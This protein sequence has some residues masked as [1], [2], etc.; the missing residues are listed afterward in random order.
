MPIVIQHSASFW[1]RFERIL[2]AKP[3]H[4]TNGCKYTPSKPGPTGSLGIANRTTQWRVQRPQYKTTKYDD[5]KK[6]EPLV[7]K[8]RSVFG[9]TAPVSTQGW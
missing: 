5:T 1:P 7:E 3:T 8:Q 4:I 6:A 2:V 9:C